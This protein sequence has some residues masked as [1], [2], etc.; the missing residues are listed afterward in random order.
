MPGFTLK[1]AIPSPFSGDRMALCFACL[2]S[3]LL[4]QD[5]DEVVG[6]DPVTVAVRMERLERDPV[7]AVDIEHV[8]ARGAVEFLDKL[9]Q[10]VLMCAAER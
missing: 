4:P 3:V 7:C 8:I 5:R 2:Q 9:A 10:I 6:D 1:R